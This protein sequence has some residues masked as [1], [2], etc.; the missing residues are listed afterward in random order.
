MGGGGGRCTPQFYFTRSPN[1]NVIDFYKDTKNS[2]LKTIM[3]TAN[4]HIL[5]S[6][7]DD[8]DLSLGS[9]LVIHG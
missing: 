6:W 8:D 3:R 4:V 2:E 7:N 9:K 1:R 5:V